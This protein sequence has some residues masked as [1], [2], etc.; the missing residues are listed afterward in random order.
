M[1]IEFGLYAL[2]LSLATA[3]V[4]SVLPVLGA[5]RGDANLMAVAPVAALAQFALVTIAF[6]ILMH[7]RSSM[8]GRIRIR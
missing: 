6:G 4:L 8:S 7:S 1:I 3:I 5:R 2:V